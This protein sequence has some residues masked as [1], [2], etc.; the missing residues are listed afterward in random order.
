MTITQI[1]R[2]PL[3]LPAA[4]D[5]EPIAAVIAAAP[6]IAENGV[7]GHGAE[8]ATLAELAMSSGHSPVLVDVMLDPEQPG[9]AR[10]RAFG[11]LLSRTSHRIPA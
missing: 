11:M 3:R 9:V 8:L 5:A 1:T 6:D 4:P 7:M 10:T 2:P